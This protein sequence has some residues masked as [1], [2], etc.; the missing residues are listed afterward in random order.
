MTR[1]ERTVQPDT[2][3]YVDTVVFTVNQDRSPS[4]SGA[5]LDPADRLEVLT[6]RR[7]DAEPG[8]WA[9]PGSLVG[10]DEDLPDAAVRTVQAE[11]GVSL[12]P[13]DVHQVA[14][15]GHPDRDPR[16]RAI[17]VAYMAIVPHATPGGETLSEHSR[18]A[19]FQPYRSLRWQRPRVLEFDHHEIIYDARKAAL[20]LLEDRAVVFSFL[21][22]KFSMTDMRL[23]YEAFLQQ[24]IDPANF[25]R[26]VEA[27]EDLVVPI[28]EWTDSAGRRGRPAQLYTAGPL[29][30]SR[31]TGSAPRIEP[32]IRFRRMHDGSDVAL[33][34]E[35]AR[36]RPRKP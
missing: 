5:G 21:P 32:P 33:P 24:R 1:R 34:A 18:E 9:L 20:R 6:M 8:M 23:V 30:G 12:R 31:R 25:R 36:R 7:S 14:T 28:E 16:W 13:G 4:E 22:A 15:Y 2:F 35:R 17:S 11:T 10:D 27:I 29:A 26:K 3:V 19:R